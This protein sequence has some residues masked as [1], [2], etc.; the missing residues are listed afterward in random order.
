[1]GLLRED[2]VRRE[3]FAEVVDERSEVVLGRQGGNAPQGTVALAEAKA[4]WTDTLG[5]VS[6]HEGQFGERVAHDGGITRPS[7]S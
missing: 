7:A 4:R 3:G 2:R 6:D 1:M 5:R